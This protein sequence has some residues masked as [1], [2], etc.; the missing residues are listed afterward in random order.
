MSEQVFRLPDI[1]EGLADAEIVTWL[2]GVGD[3][4]R[5]DQPVVTVETAKA[6][7]ELPAPADGVIVS[8]QAAVADVVN[9][10]DPLFVIDASQ[11]H[12]E[13]GGQTLPAARETSTVGALRVLAAPSTRRLAVELGVDLN[14]LTGTGPNGRITADDIRAS[15]AG[16]F[17]APAP[18]KVAA[19][20]ESG[21]GAQASPLRGLRRQMAAAM[22]AASAVPQITEFREID[23]SALRQAH[24]D[25]R[26]V[27]GD[28]A[29]LTVLP[30]LIRA[31][32]EAVRQHSMMN[33]T[34]DM[35]A[36]QYTLHPA[37]HV[38]I[39]VATPDGL[40]APVLRD[41][42]KLTIAGLADEI[43][44]ISQASRSRSL[45]VEEVAG[46]TITISNFG[47]YGTWL[48]TPLVMPPQVAIVGFG[49]IRDAVIPVDGVPAV[50][51]ILPLAVSADHRLIDGAQ[52][53]A[54]VNA[55]E[56]LIRTPLLMVGQ[57]D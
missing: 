15:T 34:L 6:Q 2:V 7:V 4:V 38:G 42:D 18:T 54:F 35:A 25:L 27:I 3:Q 8:L 55:L 57:V 26:A 21:S 40:V 51:P 12:V 50:R 49:R 24:R 20:T 19:Q 17:P 1:G 10:G 31:V 43:A 56:Q 9:V 37:Y 28:R 13:P 16:D 48:G 23:A 14:N 32:I 52:L 33:A 11:A 30:L 44:R 29:R 39:A 53:G 45:A 46:G 47:S 22:T 5:A 41:A 36:Q